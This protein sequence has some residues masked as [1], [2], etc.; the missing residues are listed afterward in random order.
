MLITF[1]FNNLYSNGKSNCIELFSKDKNVKFVEKYY[2]DGG[3]P[4]DHRAFELLREAAEEK[5]VRLMVHVNIDDRDM[6]HVFYISDEDIIQIR[7]LPDYKKFFST[8]L[9]STSL[10]KLK[11][12]ASILDIGALVELGRRYYVGAGVPKNYKKAIEFLI[13]VAGQK[14]EMLILRINK[15]SRD[16][17]HI[18]MNNLHIVRVEELFE[19][20]KKLSKSSSNGL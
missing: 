5:D 11:T 16:I 12:K 19:L 14:N 10:S 15:N 6:L 13:K 8:G 3:F 7:K 4:E 9:I 1:N 18:F 17:L 20:F 2:A